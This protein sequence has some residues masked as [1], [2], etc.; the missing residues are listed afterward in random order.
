MTV[1]F[2]EKTYNKTALSNKTNCKKTY[3][4]S[5]HIAIIKLYF[6]CLIMTCK[7]GRCCLDISVSC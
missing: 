1:E 7:D 4:L 6:E 2:K 3:V 5:M